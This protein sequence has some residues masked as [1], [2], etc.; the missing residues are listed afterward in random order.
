MQVSGVG[1]LPHT[2]HSINSK[3]LRDFDVR[4]DIL[5]IPEKNIGK[6]FS[7]INHNNI[8]LGQSPKEKERKG[9]TSK[10]DLIKLCTVK[11]TKQK[12]ERVYGPGENI[13]KRYDQQGLNFQNI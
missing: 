11:E 13:R 5:K 1:A 2:V 12:D 10:W 6:T 7:D 8:F 3:W 4:H 9:K